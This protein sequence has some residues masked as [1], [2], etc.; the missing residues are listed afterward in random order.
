MTE[1][2]KKSVPIKEDHR[3][4]MASAYLNNSPIPEP[5]PSSKKNVIMERERGWKNKLPVNQPT[6]V[7]ERRETSFSR[8]P[9]R[10]NQTQ[11]GSISDHWKNLFVDQLAP[12]NDVNNFLLL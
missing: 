11:A 5:K 9:R 12:Q 3:K 1:R 10:K 2:N 7:S 6:I 4:S 8:S